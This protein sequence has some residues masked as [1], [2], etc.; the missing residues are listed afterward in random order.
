MKTTGMSLA[1]AVLVAAA[2]A[3][4]D[5]KAFGKPLE[6][7]PVVKLADVLAH[8]EDGKVVRV[9]GTVHK[10]CQNQGCWL[11]LK[12]G[13]KAVMVRMAG[14]AFSVPKDSAGRKVVLEGKVVVKKAKADEVEHLKG[15]GAS[16]TAAADVS[17]E[18]T[19]VEL[20]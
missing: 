17:I 1:F 13:D 10:V 2:P 7:K 19:G 20:R 11:E 16:A 9:E 18:A 6:G 14:H 4:A 8:P 3:L 5:G 12:D 15:E